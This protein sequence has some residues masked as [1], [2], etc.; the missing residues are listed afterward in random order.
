MPGET[1]GAPVDR[2][3]PECGEPGKL[4]EPPER[5]GGRLPDSLGPGPPGPRHVG[6]SPINP[7]AGRSLGTLPQYAWEMPQTIRPDPVLWGISHDICG[8]SPSPAAFDP[9]FGGLFPTRGPTV[10]S[11][12]PGRRPRLPALPRAS[13][14][15]IPPSLDP[16]PSGPMIDP[17]GR[18]RVST[19]PPPRPRSRARPPAAAPAR[20]AAG[21]SRLSA[22]PPP[23]RASLRP[24]PGTARRRWHSAP[25]G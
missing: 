15:P 22:P 24:S 16:D 10:G 21:R 3:A 7:A 5:R 20:P 12:P 13:S 11:Q 14:P 17:A 6:K 2:G 25:G 18:I 23:P 8:Q 4:G 1:R 19:P 9:L